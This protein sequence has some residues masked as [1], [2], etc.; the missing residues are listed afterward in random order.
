MNNKPVAPNEP[1]VLMPSGNQYVGI[2][3]VVSVDGQT[4]T[5][6]FVDTVPFFCRLETMEIKLADGGR[7]GRVVIRMHQNAPAGATLTLNNQTKA[8]PG[9][10]DV[11]FAFTGLPQGTYNFAGGFLG[12]ACVPPPPAVVPGNYYELYAQSASRVYQNETPDRAVDGDTTT[13]WG[14]GDYTGS[15]TLCFRDGIVTPSR[16]DIR[17]SQSPADFRDR[18][19]EFSHST[20]DDMSNRTKFNKSDRTANES[21]TTIAWDP[22][23]PVKCFKI[24]QRDRFASWMGVREIIAYR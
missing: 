10:A 13:Y 3:D 9:P 14:S 21:I 6:G 4:A 2:A 17:W 20:N 11:D 24:D 12:T 15:I 22:T 23:K 8:S 19:F 18:T 7:N 1:L 5:A 16:I